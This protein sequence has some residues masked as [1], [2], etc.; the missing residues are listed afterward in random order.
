MR[1][2]IYD[3]I[4][5]MH[6]KKINIYFLII[7]KCTCSIFL[8]IVVSTYLSYKTNLHKQLF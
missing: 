1:D 6:D 8:L 3:K 5:F 4:Y 2:I 7:K